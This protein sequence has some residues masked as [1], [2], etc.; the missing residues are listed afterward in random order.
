MS[1]VLKRDPAWLTR[2]IL[3]SVSG[4]ASLLSED[5]QQVQIP[6]ALL[7]AASPSVRTMVS[8]LHPA[9]HSPLFLCL[10]GRSVIGSISQIVYHMFS[11][12]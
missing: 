8:D 7:L 1:Y 3:G 10:P 5:G 12:S 4:T 11:L 6:T 9:A 2:P